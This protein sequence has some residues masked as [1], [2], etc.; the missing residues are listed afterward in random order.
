MATNFGSE[1]RGIRQ[2][3]GETLYQ[4]AAAIGIDRSHLTKIEL[5]QDRPSERIVQALFAHFSLKRVTAARLW[6][7]AG[8][9]SELVMAEDYRG[10]EI[11]HMSNVPANLPIQPASVNVD[12]T[13]PT[14]YTDSIFINS[15]DFG[16]VIDFA[17]KVG[18]EQHFVVTSVGMSF[19][20]A[21][22][23]VEVLNDHLNKH[24]R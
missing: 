17:R 11:V 8:F 23:L 5:G 1:I 15:S 14:Y 3:T 2:A 12:P 24:E 16:L 9:T 19:D 6:S 13:K 10:K 7:L 20:H 22:K 4:T 21:K 18:P